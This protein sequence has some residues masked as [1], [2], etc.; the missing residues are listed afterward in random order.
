ML[1]V[2]AILVVGIGVGLPRQSTPAHL[3]VVPGGATNRILEGGTNRLL[4][5]GTQ[6]ILEGS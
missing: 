2:L 1:L 6:R 3:L 4:E 5:G